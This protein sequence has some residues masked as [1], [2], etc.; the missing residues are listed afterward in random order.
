[1]TYNYDD[2]VRHVEETVS[3]IEKAAKD[4]DKGGVSNGTIRFTKLLGENPG[5]LPMEDLNK[6][7]E[8]FRMA[9]GQ[10]VYK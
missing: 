6:Y 3:G 1:M 9:M 2:L 7:T 10:G 8:R 4:K 5:V